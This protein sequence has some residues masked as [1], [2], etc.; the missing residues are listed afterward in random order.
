MLLADLGADVIRIERKQLPGAPNPTP[1]L[2]PDTT[3]WRA[4]VCSLALDLKRSEGAHPGARFDRPSR[5]VARRLSPGCH[6][7]A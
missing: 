3:S 4:A 2:A 1:L 7:K 6:G 5:C